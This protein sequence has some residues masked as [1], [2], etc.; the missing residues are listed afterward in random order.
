MQNRPLNA[1]NFAFC[2]VSHQYEWH[3]FSRIKILAKCTIF[4]HTREIRWNLTTSASLLKTYFSSHNSCIPIGISIGYLVSKRNLSTVSDPLYS[5]PA[6]YNWRCAGNTF[7]VFH[8]LFPLGSSTQTQTTR[9][10]LKLG[11]VI[12]SPDRQVEQLYLFKQLPL[13]FITGASY[14]ILIQLNQQMNYIGQPSSST[15]TI[16]I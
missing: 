14:C 9:D 4:W 2:N 13:T 12:S 11:A 1:T 15:I 6:K 8:S 3:T 5:H 16:T 7:I 10:G